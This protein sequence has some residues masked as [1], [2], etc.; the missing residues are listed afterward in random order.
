M[1]CLRGHCTMIQEIYKIKFAEHQKLQKIL[2]GKAL[3]KVMNPNY[4]NQVREKG[5]DID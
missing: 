5:G 2:I 3:S 4:W 1:V